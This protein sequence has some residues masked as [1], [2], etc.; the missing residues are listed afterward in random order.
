MFKGVFDVLLAQEIVSNLPFEKCGNSIHLPKPEHR[1]YKEI[2]EKDC[3][4]LNFS[5]GVDVRPTRT[6][7]GTISKTLLRAQNL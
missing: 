2:F 7:C 3:I 4:F 6:R 5:T 1:D